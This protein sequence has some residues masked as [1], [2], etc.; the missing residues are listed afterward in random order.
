MPNQTSG[1]EKCVL[2]PHHSTRAMSTSTWVTTN[3]IGA[4]VVEQPGAWID[5]PQ[6][7]RPPRL[8]VGDEDQHGADEFHE[9]ERDHEAAEQPTARRPEAPWL[10]GQEQWSGHDRSVGL[11]DGGGHRLP[12]WLVLA[13]PGNGGAS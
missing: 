1:I 13:R 2:S 6:S 4:R 10:L 3:R 8:A 5:E 12:P 7:E 9:G 11:G